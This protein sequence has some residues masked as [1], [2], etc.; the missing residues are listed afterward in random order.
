META[1][2]QDLANKLN[3]SFE[4][5][6]QFLEGVDLELRAYQDSNW[7]IREVLGHLA[8]WDREVTKSIQA[9]TEGAEYAIAKLELDSFNQSKVDEH[10]SW[11]SLQ[12]CIDTHG[13]YC[14]QNIQGL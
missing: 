1:N 11:T 3:Q 12:V 7:R 2:Q 9:F 4:V 13:K 10:Q 6:N 8:S 14:P 5:V